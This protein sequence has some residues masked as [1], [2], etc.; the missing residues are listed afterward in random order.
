MTLEQ[1][2]FTLLQRSSEELSNWIETAYLAAVP[3]AEGRVEAALGA[4]LDWVAAE[5]VGARA[6][7]V[8]PADAGPGVREVQLAAFRD[9][10]DLLRRTM[11]PDP[12]RPS[13]VEE[14]V[15]GALVAILRTLLIAGEHER[16]PELRDGIGRFVLYSFGQESQS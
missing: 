10:I 5:P 8:E 16:A 3:S 7:L 11:P 2:Q 12:A 6:L 9:G 13:C 4:L 15:V 14:V 1:E